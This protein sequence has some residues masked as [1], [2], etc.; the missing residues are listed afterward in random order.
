MI[1][2]IDLGTT[3][4]LVG[5]YDNDGP[6]LIRNALGDLLTPSVISIGDDGEVIVGRAARDRLISHPTQSV[7]A[8]KRLMGTGREVA[9]GDKSFRAEELSAL[10]LRSLLADAR[11]ALGIEIA[12]AVIS[13]PA[14]FGDAQRRATRTAG[15]LAGLR[16]ERLIN[17]PTAAALAYGLDE[18]LDG[19]TFIVLDLG[20]GTF[21]VSILEVFDG[22]MKVHA[23][24]GD[25]RL[26]GEDFVQMLVSECARELRLVETLF[27]PRDRSQIHAAMERLK[28]EL[29]SKQEGEARFSIGDRS[30]EWRISDERFAQICEPL[31]QRIRKPVER[32]MRDA[33]IGTGDLAE[34]VLV[35]GASR[36]PVVAKLVTRMFGRLPLRHVNPDE[37]IAR[38]ACVAAGM[39][40]RHK[41]LDEVVMTDVC[42]YT[43][44]V[45]I[46]RR[47][48][49]GNMSNGHFSPIIE[50][51]V[52]VPVSRSGPYFPTQ[53]GQRIVLLEI[54]QGESPFVAN[55]VRLGN[56]EVPV[57]PD[58]A[59]PEEA[60]VD[61]RFTYDVNGVLQVEA[62]VKATKE[63]FEL[64]L[65]GSEAG[66]NEAE[67]R[68]R[69]ARLQ[70]LKVHP[71]HH[72]E[73]IA[74]IAR[75]E[76]AYEECLG[77]EREYIQRWLTAFL[78]EIERQEPAAIAKAREE[79][80]RAL[81]SLQGVTG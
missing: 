53:R 46:V 32:A 69:L 81:D 78:A 36:M 55:N 51:N 20:G 60:E 40:S 2:G 80:S 21:D 28:I 76:R 17:E 38:G 14:Y 27:S 16:I 30:Y 26:G 72:Q 18:R 70:D 33:R 52:T 29:S 12:E 15:E 77:E 9:L 61:V 13:V 10:V 66:L 34:I 64:I 62:T 74:A 59:S 49:A 37:A 31:L 42:P 1:L 23:S 71:R 6:R 75:A 8:F 68:E 67:I 54:Y 45:A 44:G 65:T 19:S 57:P 79:F 25:N 41:A 4:S 5:L 11:D 47:D 56:L 73:N 43:L 24:A 63:R 48:A 35:G 22:V 39:K 7:A 58:A 3:N 50:R